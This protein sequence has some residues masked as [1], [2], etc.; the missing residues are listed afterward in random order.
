MR[1]L[2]SCVPGEGH[3]RPLLPLARALRARGHEVAFAVAES[4][5]PRVTDEGFAALAAGVE[6]DTARASIPNR[7][8]LLAAPPSERRALLFPRLFGVGHAPAKLP[9]L[10]EHVRAW[11][12]DGVVYDSS[13]LAAPIAAYLEFITR[14]KPSRDGSPPATVHIARKSAGSS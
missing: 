6:H 8:E 2:F 12:P 11:R 7:A 10:L 5:T 4:W 1:I 13:D 9:E 3:V 14:V